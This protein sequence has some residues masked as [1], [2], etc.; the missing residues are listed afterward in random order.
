MSSIICRITFND[1]LRSYKGRKS[2]KDYCTPNDFLNH[3]KLKQLW[4]WLKWSKTFLRLKLARL[5]SCIKVVQKKIIG[6]DK[7]KKLFP[8]LITF[9]E[10]KKLLLFFY[11]WTKV[12]LTNAVHVEL[13]FH[14]QMRKHVFCHSSKSTMYRNGIWISG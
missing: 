12:C 6:N 10:K 3:F 4:N 11:E 9:S 13:I 8:L 5:V 7:I 14:K 2:Q 1:R